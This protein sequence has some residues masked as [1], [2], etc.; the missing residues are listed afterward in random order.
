MNRV[1]D[2]L[3]AVAF[4]TA[5]TVLTLAAA[6][7]EASA[8]VLDPEEAAAAALIASLP[9]AAMADFT[10]F[11]DGEGLLFVQASGLFVEG[12]GFLAGA[13]FIAD[14]GLTLPDPAGPVAGALLIE[15]GTTLLLIGEAVSASLSGGALAVTI[16]ALDGSLAPL[17]SGG[18]ALTL[19]FPDLPAGGGLIDF[20][21]DAGSASVTLSLASAG[22]PAPVPLGS[23][24]GFL[25]ASLATLGLGRARKQRRPPTG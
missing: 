10:D 19:T 2:L 15:D 25:I 21:A 5:A 4:A 14:L 9:G 6:S 18:A 16:G 13:T 12:S 3:A 17:F 11:G 8:A 23:A 7:D 22:P 24:A 20:L 1:Y